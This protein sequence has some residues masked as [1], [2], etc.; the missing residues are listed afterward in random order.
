MVEKQAP[1]SAKP[2]Q[3]KPHTVGCLSASLQNPAAA[4]LDAECHGWI[5]LLAC[6]LCIPGSGL[7]PLWP[8]SLLTLF[9]VVCLI[10]LPTAP[11]THTHTHTER[12]CYSKSSVLNRITCISQFPL[13][14][15]CSA[16]IYF[17]VFTLKIDFSFWSVV[18]YPWPIASFL[19]CLS[20]FFALCKGMEWDRY[21]EGCLI[22]LDFF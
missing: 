10:F 9:L 18:Q 3:P 2:N 4:P 16:G 15:P 11:N 6:C 7:F 1:R 19:S 5:L 12:L 21:V 14:P 17:C 20:F 22:R 13:G 8:F